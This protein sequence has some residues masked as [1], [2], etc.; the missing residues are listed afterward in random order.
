MNFIIEDFNFTNN[1]MNGLYNIT[2]LN[3]EILLDNNLNKILI[4]CL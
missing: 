4:D 2:L 1:F 3:K